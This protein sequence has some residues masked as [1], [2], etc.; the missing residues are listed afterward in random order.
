MCAH[1]GKLAIRACPAVQIMR[2]ADPYLS[3]V[4]DSELAVVAKAQQVIDAFNKSQGFT[5]TPIYLNRPS[6]WGFLSPPS[7][8]GKKC[9]VEPLV[10]PFVKYN[11]NSGWTQSA[12]AC[13][14][15]QV[16]QVCASTGCSLDQ[17]CCIIPAHGLLLMRSSRAVCVRAFQSELARRRSACQTWCMHRRAADG[18]EE[19]PAHCLRSR[20][21]K[22]V[23]AVARPALDAPCICAFMCLTR[24]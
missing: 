21:A 23:D 18:A 15:H 12:A 8:E 19:P 1:N 11:S 5:V 7:W 24:C 9:L 13:K 20:L 3:A 4:F 16:M 6:V 10:E 22:H 14:W 17:S 2:G